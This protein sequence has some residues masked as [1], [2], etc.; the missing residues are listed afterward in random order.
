MVVD[1]H[2]RRHVGVVSLLCVCGL[3]GLI[4]VYYLYLI[5]VGL[6][7]LDRGLIKL[8]RVGK[9]GLLKLHHPYLISTKVSK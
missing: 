5:Q 7:E 9:L 4:K 6:I 8:D 1:E 3:G 2:G